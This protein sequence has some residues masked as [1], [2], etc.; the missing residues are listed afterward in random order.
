MR[1]SFLTP[2]AL[3]LGL[4]LALPGV[5]QPVVVHFYGGPGSL[6]G[7]FETTEG[8]PD[9]QGWIGVDRSAPEAVHFH[10]DTYH[11]ANLDPRVPGNHAWWSGKRFDEC[12]GGDDPEGYGS[13]W[14][15]H[16]DWF[17]TV[18]D[19][20]LP[21]TVHVTAVVNAD[22][23]PVEDFVYL[24]CV[25]PAGQWWLELLDL[26]GKHD[27]L[28]VSVS[29]LLQP[30]DYVG[31]AGDQV[32][33]RW[34]V[35]SDG[36]WDDSDCRYPSQGAMQIDRI[37]VTFD[38]G[39]GPVQIGSL[40]TCEPGSIRQWQP[41]SVL[42]AGDYSKVWPLLFGAG[43]GPPNLTPQFAFI[44]DGVVVPGTGGTLC[45]VWCYGPGGYTPNHTGGLSSEFG[46]RYLHNV[47]LSPAVPVPPVVDEA[48]AEPEADV[49]VYL[50]FDVYRHENLEPDSPRLA[51]L[52]QVRSTDDP[53]DPTAWFDWS[54]G[55]YGAGGPEY[56]RHHEDIT[57]WVQGEFVQVALGVYQFTWHANTH[58]TP[59]PYFDNVALSYELDSPADVPVVAPTL[60]LAS[61][62]PNPFN[63]SA[64]ITFT[65][66]GSGPVDLAVFDLT[67]R[68]VRTLLSGHLDGGEQRVR[69]DGKDE[70]GRMAAAGSY[71]ISLTAAGERVT[72]KGSLLK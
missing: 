30:E 71:L 14:N 6:D 1:P 12:G 55:V 36:A 60:S 22:V 17:G 66:A 69:W 70:G 9:R 51:Y 58:A 5:A 19:P 13:N 7:R 46:T 54:P 26:T 23:E 68:R 38:Q 15:D 24:Y 25:L 63:P 29:C 21:V 28:A 43:T 33:L 18:S 20:D 4:C 42:G 62:V 37:R 65:L 61:P 39:A 48:R 67:G 31:T 11:C 35:N 44:D 3:L 56:F 59:A 72:R 32:H 47:I 8:F 45:E 49:A 40:E 50:D 27:S 57:E 52:W 53:A 10:I 64:E 2:G 16:L 34:V 41:V